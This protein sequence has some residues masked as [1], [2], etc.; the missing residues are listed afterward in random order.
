[1]V[2][3]LTCPGYTGHV[4]MYVEVPVVE[5]ALAKAE[6]F[7]G[8]RMMGPDDAGGCGS[9]RSMIPKA[10]DPAGLGDA[11]RTRRGG[12]SNPRWLI[13]TPL[14]ESGTINHSDTSPPPS[15]GERFGDPSGWPRGGWLQST[16]ERSPSLVEGADLES[17]YPG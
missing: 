1:M 11:V 4:T 2:R 14:F 3:A 7:G 9:Q 17:R 12:D 16:T 8:S 15:I 5:A 6:S 13:T 10:P